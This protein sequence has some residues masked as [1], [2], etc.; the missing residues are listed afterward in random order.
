MTDKTM[1]EALDHIAMLDGPDGRFDA[2][3]IASL[4]FIRT[5]AAEIRQNA[6][7]SRRLKALEQAMDEFI[8]ANV[9]YVVKNAAVAIRER[10]DEIMRETEVA[11]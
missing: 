8:S 2:T 5:H 3:C 6:I 1:L 10:A 7:D 4:K 9:R 11:G